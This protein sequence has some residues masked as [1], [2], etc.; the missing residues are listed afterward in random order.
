MEMLIKFI[1]QYGLEV[2][3]IAF[4][5]IFLVG[6]FKLI[7]NK[8]LEKIKKADRKPIYETFSIVFAFGLTAAWLAVR[9]SWFHMPLDPF[10]WKLVAEAGIGVYAAVKVMY[11]LYE[12]YKLRD[13]LQIIGRWVLSWFSHKEASVKPEGEEG[14]S[15]HSGPTVL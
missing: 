5:T 3:L 1:E 15:T 13:L 7:L 2:A 6:V 8:P 11:P 14:N 12:N 4:A 10:S 9:V